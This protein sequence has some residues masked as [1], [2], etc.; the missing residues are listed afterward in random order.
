MATLVAS[1]TFDDD[2]VLSVAEPA[3]GPVGVA[4]N[5]KSE[6]IGWG[7]V[8]QLQQSRTFTS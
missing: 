3:K 2:S 5:T 7:T 1:A 4:V 8:V 6:A